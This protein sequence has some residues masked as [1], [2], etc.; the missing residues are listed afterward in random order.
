MTNAAVAQAT[1]VLGDLPRDDDGPVFREPWEAQAFAIALSLHERGLFSWKE[2]AAALADEIKLAQ[3]NGDPDTGTT[4]YRHWLAALEKLV[5]A[6]G[7]ATL[8]TQHR[9]RDAWDHAADRTPHGLPIELKP[10]DFPPTA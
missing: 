10:E 1:S 2:W 4:Y 6:K 8:E 3:A 5:A 9:Y 7:V